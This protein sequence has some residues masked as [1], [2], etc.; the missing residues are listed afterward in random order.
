MKEER[1][2]HETPLKIRLGEVG[3]LEGGRRELRT[4]LPGGRD[5][6]RKGGDTYR[7]G[8]SSCVELRRKQK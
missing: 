8:V 2:E 5:S 7:R 1:V 3:A 6:K 4:H